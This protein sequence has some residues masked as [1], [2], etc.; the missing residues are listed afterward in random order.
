MI[1]TV[2]S[3]LLQTYG[4]NHFPHDVCSCS[5]LRQRFEIRTGLAQIENSNKDTEKHLQIRI[6]YVKRTVR[7]LVFGVM[8]SCMM[9]SPLV[10]GRHSLLTMVTLPMLYP[11]SRINL[12]PYQNPATNVHRL[13]QHR[14]DRQCS[15]QLPN[16]YEQ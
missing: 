2:K 12:A 1:H 8:R 5:C 15:E 4:I 16:A 14:A 9:L 6:R 3:D 10:Y 11:W 7:T 13:R